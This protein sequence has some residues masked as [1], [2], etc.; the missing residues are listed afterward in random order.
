[1][2]LLSWFL[3]G[4]LTAATVLT[5]AASSSSSAGGDEQVAAI[6]RNAGPYAGGVALGMD[7]AAVEERLGGKP[8]QTRKAEKGGTEAAIWKLEGRS[9]S[10]GFNSSGKV[11]SYSIHWIGPENKIPAYS[12][13]L[14]PGFSE[15][16]RRGT[17]VFETK[18][19]DV[20]VRWTRAPVPG[21]DL[22][23]SLLSVSRSKE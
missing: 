4:L 12:D 11:A 21:Q 6:I 22:V 15:Y 19:D 20:I 10:V 18:A 3:F 9:I 16:T 8:G 17:R 5:V 2:K 14:L 1:M 13:I 23:I 7:R